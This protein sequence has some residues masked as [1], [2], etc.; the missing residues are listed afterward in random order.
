VEEGVLEENEFILGHKL[1]VKNKTQT[2]VSLAVL[3]VRNTF[4]I[5]NWHQE[6]L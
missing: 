6:E 5:I 1:S 3:A 4:G 2:V